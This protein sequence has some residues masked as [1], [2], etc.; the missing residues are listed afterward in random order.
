MKMA[1]CWE[2]VPFVRGLFIFFLERIINCF[3]FLWE[4]YDRVYH[5]FEIQIRLFEIRRNDI[6]QWEWVMGIIGIP[7]MYW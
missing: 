2:E 3:L 1:W 4:E 5:K 6:C 7:H